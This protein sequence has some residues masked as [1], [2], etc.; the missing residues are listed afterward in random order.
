[1]LA[2]GWRPCPAVRGRLHVCV[3]EGSRPYGPHLPAQ[4]SACSSLLLPERHAPT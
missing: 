1:M 4:E 2:V 3:G